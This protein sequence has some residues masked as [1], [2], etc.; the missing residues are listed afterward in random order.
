MRFDIVTGTFEDTD[1]EPGKLAVIGSDRALTWN[2]LQAEVGE[3]TSRLKSLDLPAGHLVLVHGHK[4]A[5]MVVAMLACIALDLPYIPLDIVVPLDRIERISKLTG[6]QVLLN[7]TGAAT[8]INAAIVLEQAQV[9]KRAQCTFGAD[10]LPRPHDPIR[11]IIFTSGSTGE[12]K[13][14]QITREAAASFLRWMTGDFGFTPDDVFVNQAPFSFDLSVYELFTALHTGATLL[15]NDA[16]TCKDS[17]QFLDRVRRYGGSVWVSTPTFA[18]LYLTEPKFIAAEVPML[19]SFLFCGEAL[20]KMT[21]QRLLD[22]F[23]TARVLNTYGPTEATVATTL[24]D[25]TREVLGRYADM[26]VGVPKPEGTVRTVPT[27]TKDEPGEI[28]ILGPHV[29]IGYFNNEVLNAEKFFIEDGAR[30]FR[31]GDY[32]YFLD[33][34]LFFNGRR[35]E[36]VKLNGFRI[37]LGDIT[38]QMLAVPGV[39]DAIAVPLKNG[40]TVKR[41]VG[42]IRPGGGVVQEELRGMV[43]AHLKRT[44]PEYMVPGDIAFVEAFPVN[45]SHKTDRKA[46]IEQYLKRR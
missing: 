15:L 18:Y 41:I 45:A 20:P 17:S 9:S 21:A 8:E 7:C 32:G 39:A 27:G 23:P 10:L 46:L 13:G 22:R 4:R 37:E 34:I 14:V 25:V 28:E 38:A 26:P 19:R 36:Q 33:G 35:D 12:P 42:F 3:W 1:R 30:G 24:I 40:D 16:P 43:L 11:Y 31:T 6:S 29:S 2:E 44:L 5:E